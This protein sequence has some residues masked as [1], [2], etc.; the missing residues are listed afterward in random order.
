METIGIRTGS[1][2]EVVDITGQVQDVVSKSG[3]KSGIAV[4]C[5][6]HTTAGVTINE[7]ADPDVMADVLDTLERLVPKSGA[8]SHVEGNSDAHVKTAL[9]GQ[10]VT[11]PLED[12]RLQLGTWQGVY[13]CEFDGPRQRRVMVQILPSG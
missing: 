9:V 4:V 6:A 2:V 13:F 11:V 3:A 10:S 7:N 5:T 1:R 8:Y 12:G